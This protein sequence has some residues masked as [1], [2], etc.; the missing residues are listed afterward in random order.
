GRSDMLQM[1][2]WVLPFFQGVEVMGLRKVLGVLLVL[3][4]G[5]VTTAGAQ[6]TTTGRIIGT[7][8][9]QQGAV[10]PGATVTATSPQLQGERT[11]VTDS[12]GE[13]RFLTLPP[14]MYSVKAELSG[15]QTVER[16]AV[17]V[18]VHSTV[19]LPLTMPVAGVAAEVTVSVPAP[20]VDVTSTQGGVVMDSTIFNNLPVRRDFTSVTRIAPGA[21]SDL[22]GAVMYGGTGAENGYIV[23]GVNVTGMV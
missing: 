3:M 23:D 17:R 14:G 22:Y 11:S 13:F 18:D 1:K 10:V 2:Q 19:N 15:F 12:A 20:V 4:L 8:S 6:T 5:V 21:T 9:D 16:A 7:L